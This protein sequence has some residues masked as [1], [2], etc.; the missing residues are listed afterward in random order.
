MAM[1]SLTGLPLIRLDAADSM[2]GKTGSENAAPG[3]SAVQIRTDL[4][5]RDQTYGFTEAVAPLFTLAADDIDGI[6]VLG[7]YA[8]HAQPALALKRRG[9]AYDAWSGAGPVPGAVLRELAR[10]AGVFIYSET[11]DPIYANRGLFGLYAHQGGQRTV[12]FPNNVV[13][14]DVY[15]TERQ[16]PSRD[17][18]ITL[19]CSDNEMH[20][21]MITAR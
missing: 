2:T 16:L 13:L 21:F 5:G 18:C 10:R 7:Q 8:D 1:Q 17:G 20:L 19:N 3:Q 11:D 14:Q 6:E 12:R 15:C 4:S 9:A